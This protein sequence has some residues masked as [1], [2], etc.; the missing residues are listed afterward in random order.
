V[1]DERDPMGGS[2]YVLEVSSPGVD[3]PLT[4]R[5]HWQRNLTRLVTVATV[6]GSSLTGRL[7]GVGDEGI[8]VESDG[9][10]TSLEWGRVASGRVQ[11]EFNRPRGSADEPPEEH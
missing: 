9:A 4:A 2:P 7:V 1:L 11:I 10:T 3:R 5:R 6:E 8:D